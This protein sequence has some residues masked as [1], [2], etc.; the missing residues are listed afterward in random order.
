MLGGFLARLQRKIGHDAFHKFTK[1][2][3][4]ECRVSM[5]RAINHTLFD[6]IVSERGS[7]LYVDPKQIGNIAGS[8]RIF[9]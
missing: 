8:L 2:G 6:E 4:G 3:H 7:T 5:A 1:K 9:P